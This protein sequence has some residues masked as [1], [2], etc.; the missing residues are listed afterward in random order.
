[1]GGEAADS[2]SSYGRTE[3]NPLLGKTFGPR[4]CLTKAAFVGILV[5]AEQTKVFK[6]HRRATKVLNYVIGGVSF[7]AAVRNWRIN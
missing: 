5:W 3:L 4:G 1:M 6:Q 2:F 7:G